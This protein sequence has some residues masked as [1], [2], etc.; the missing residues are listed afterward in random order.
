MLSPDLIKPFIRGIK[1]S[2]KMKSKLI[3]SQCS[4]PS[5]EFRGRITIPN[6]FIST[7]KMPV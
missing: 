1:T 7:R 3:S 2:L 4:N 6:S 5:Q